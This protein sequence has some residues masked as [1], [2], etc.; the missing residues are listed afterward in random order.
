MLAFVSFTTPAYSH[1]NHPIKV[2]RHGWEGG[3][4][5]VYGVY[6][7]DTKKDNRVICALYDKAGS[8]IVSKSGITSPLATKIL[9]ILDLNSVK[10]VASAKCVYD[11]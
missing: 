8:L 5:M 6:L 10:P 4:D 2:A 11:R 7:Q 9:I 1:K 3:G